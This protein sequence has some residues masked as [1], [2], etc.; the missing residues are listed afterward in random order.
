M[1]QKRLRNGPPSSSQCC[2]GEFLQGQQRT[3]GPHRRSLLQGQHLPSAKKR[4]TTGKKGRELEKRPTPGLHSRDPK[5]PTQRPPKQTK[6]HTTTVPGDRKGESRGKTRQPDKLLRQAGPTRNRTSQSP[7]QPRRVWRTPH[8]IHTPEKTQ[9][10]PPAGH[11]RDCNMTARPARTRSPRAGCHTTPNKPTPTS[12][13][14]ATPTP[15]TD[16]HSN[17]T[18]GGKRCSHG[19]CSG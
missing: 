18:T 12:N 9:R 6:P 8:G 4:A 17:R 19:P 7:A 3:L 16:S 5:P 1:K 2:Q 14:P 13:N 10:P 15:T 11:R